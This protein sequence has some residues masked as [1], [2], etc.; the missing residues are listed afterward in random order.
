MVENDG[1]TSFFTQLGLIWFNP[2]KIWNIMRVGVY[3]QLFGGMHQQFDWEIKQ[4][5]YG[6]INW[7]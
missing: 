7:N 1:I 5:F 6:D 2:P 3:Y 4:P